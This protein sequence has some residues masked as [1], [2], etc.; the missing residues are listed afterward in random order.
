[1]T[2]PFSPQ[3][4]VA[5]A[6]EVDRGA[7]PASV[8]KHLNRLI[9]EY[10]FQ[11]SYSDPDQ[12]LIATDAFPG[13]LV[14]QSGRWS[15]YVPWALVFAFPSPDVLDGLV[16]VAERSMLQGRGNVVLSG[17]T[18]FAGRFAGLGDID[19]A[20]YVFDDVQ[21]I[22]SRVHELAHRDG[23]AILVRVRCH[24]EYIAPWDEL[25]AALHGWTALADK[26]ERIK[27]DFIDGATPF[28]LMP[29]SN[30]VL[31]SDAGDHTKGAARKSFVFQEAVLALTDNPPWPLVMAEEL[32]RYLRFL[33]REILAYQTDNPMKAV[34]RALSLVRIVGLNDLGARAETVLASQAANMAAHQSCLRELDT[35][36]THVGAA[37]RAN[38]EAALA[39]KKE[40]A[41]SM[42]VRASLAKECNAIV[43]EALEK[44]KEFLFLEG[45]SLEAWAKRKP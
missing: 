41:A 33:V 17:S 35:L 28:G 45:E 25:V 24:G 1:M 44:M 5:L 26:S 16:A 3:D 37:R 9:A 38:L 39:K 12:R 43:T 22:A 18:T 21:D 42:D 10:A 6:V 30:I 27:F 11:N 4:I 13:Y 15:V 7:A 2:S 34:K 14:T 20:Q 32:L 23:P 36:W 31:P 8:T 29:V 19:L 40:M